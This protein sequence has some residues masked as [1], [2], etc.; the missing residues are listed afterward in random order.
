MMSIYKEK[1]DEDPKP[2]EFEEVKAKIDAICSKC[3]RNQDK[4][5]PCL[6]VCESVIGYFE[7]LDELDRRDR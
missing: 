4:D 2:T 7:R 5:K 6:I 3:E 1:M